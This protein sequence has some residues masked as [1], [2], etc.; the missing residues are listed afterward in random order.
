MRG[1]RRRVRPAGCRDAGAG[2][3]EPL[4]LPQAY[5]HLAPLAG[6]A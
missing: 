5:S 6:V 2:K 3:I 4:I 1:A